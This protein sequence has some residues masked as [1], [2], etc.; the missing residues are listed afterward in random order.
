MPLYPSPPL[1]TRVSLVFVRTLTPLSILIDLSSGRLVRRVTPA[2]AP[3][4]LWCALRA[5][6]TTLSALEAA[7]PAV[8]PRTRCSVMVPAASS[9]AWE[10]FPFSPGGRSRRIVLARALSRAVVC[11][12]VRDRM[13]IPFFGERR[14]SEHRYFRNTTRYLSAHAYDGFH[15]PL[16]IAAPLDGSDAKNI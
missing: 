7:T 15:T 16:R 8:L 12:C 3:T 11:T 6:R 5:R 2:L 13:L 14:A 1:S 9:A 10:P 4:G